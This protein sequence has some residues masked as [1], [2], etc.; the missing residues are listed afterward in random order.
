MFWLRVTLGII[1]LG[2]NDPQENAD[3]QTVNVFFLFFLV[4]FWET[5]T[6]MDNLHIDQ[7]FQIWI[8]I[9]PVSEGSGDVM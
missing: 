3:W 1:H 8:F 6:M 4:F 7:I 9:S 2:Q 5:K